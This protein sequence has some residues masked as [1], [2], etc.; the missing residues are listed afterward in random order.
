MDIPKLTV[1]TEQG[2]SRVLS[3]FLLSF[4]TDFLMRWFYPD[5]NDYVNC[6][7]GFDAFCGGAIDHGSAYRS[8]NFEG[9]AMWFPPGFGPDE[10][11]V[12]GFLE[13]TIRSEIL[14]DVFLVFEAI[15]N[16]HPTEP[17]WYLSVIGVD[18]AYQGRGIGAALMKH[19]LLRPDEEGIPSYLESSNPRNISFYERHGFQIMGEIQI[20]S[21]PTITPMIRSVGA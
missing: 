19:S 21:S 20:G 11:K 9:A 2:R 16:Y 7:P 15:G 1:V 4:S 10:E 8:G 13:R 14:E 5:A 17:C 3:T 18:P 12:A 6:I